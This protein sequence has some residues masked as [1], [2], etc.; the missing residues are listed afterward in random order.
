MIRRARASELE[1]LAALWERSVRATQDFL[2]ESD[3]EELRAQVREALFLEPARRGRGGGDG[4]W[5]S[6]RRRCAAA[7]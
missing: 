1:A 2:T 7:I 6:T 3:I 5:W 4:G